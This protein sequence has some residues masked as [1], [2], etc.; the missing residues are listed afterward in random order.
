M[1]ED[2]YSLY[3]SGDR[4][5]AQVKIGTYENGKQ[6]YKRFYSQRQKDVVRRVVEYLENDYIL[7][8]TNKKNRRLNGRGIS[9]LVF[10]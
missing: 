3:K 7:N 10:E 6:K 4:W 8:N 2:M 9:D 5:V 1:Y